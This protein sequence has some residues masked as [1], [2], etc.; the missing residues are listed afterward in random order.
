MKKKIDPLF[1][2]SV[3]VLALGIFALACSWV[4]SWSQRSESSNVAKAETVS[5]GSVSN[6]DFVIGT[7]TTAK[8]WPTSANYKPATT[9]YVTSYLIGYMVKGLPN[10]SAFSALNTSATVKYELNISFSGLVGGV[11]HV[12]TSSLVYTN[13]LYDMNIAVFSVDL[14][15]GGED[16]SASMYTDTVFPPDLE[17]FNAF[18]NKS[19]DSRFCVFDGNGVGSDISISYVYKENDVEVTSDN[20]SANYRQFLSIVNDCVSYSPVDFVAY[21][22]FLLNQ[23]GSVLE[24]QKKYDTLLK[25]YQQV[26]NDYSALL[27]AVSRTS[28]G[29]LGDYSSPSLIQDSTGAGVDYSYVGPQGVS[30]V[31]WVDYE[32]RKFSS[33]YTYLTGNKRYWYSDT[34]TP[35]PQQD[36]IFIGCMLGLRRNFPVGAVLNISMPEVTT[37]KAYVGVFDSVRNVIEYR[38]TLSAGTSLSFVLLQNREFTLDDKLVFY[39]DFNDLNFVETDYFYDITWQLSVFSLD[40]QKYYDAGHTAGYAEGQ[41]SMQGAIENARQQGFAEAQKMFDNGNAD[42]SF[43][44]L[45]SAVIDAPVKAVRGL[46]NFDILGVN[47]FAF[48]TS[49]FS[50]AVILMLIKFILGTRGV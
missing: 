17:A 46:L 9:S 4:P 1:A 23:G 13:N 12:T 19:F 30:T 11:P 20:L 18:R 14:L 45:I 2:L 22:D 35:P 24:L 33:T 27:G 37:S 8:F 29:V 25:S 10:V 40:T 7:T 32:L 43:F 44:G 48:V 34:H 47:M 6:T 41:D 42:Y 36:T 16:L 38:A 39:F 26:Q 5:A 49:L 28:L 31:S 21:G 50:L 15:G 3:L